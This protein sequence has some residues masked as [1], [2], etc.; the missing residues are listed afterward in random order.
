M[1]DRPAVKGRPAER[2]GPGPGAPQRRAGRAGRARAGRAPG[3][4]RSAAAAIRVT[5]G[6]QHSDGGLVLATSLY[7]DPAVGPGGDAPAGLDDYLS[8]DCEC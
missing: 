8:T 3:R 1:R 6:H 2:A 7:D 5:C 4:V